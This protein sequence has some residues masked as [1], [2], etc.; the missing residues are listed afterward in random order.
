MHWK[1]KGCFRK[2]GKRLWDDNK[3]WIIHREGTNSFEPSRLGNL[4]GPV[5][6]LAVY[7]P[8]GLWTEYNQ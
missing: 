7:K 5:M 1:N 6:P 3:L 8:A 2:E 4:A